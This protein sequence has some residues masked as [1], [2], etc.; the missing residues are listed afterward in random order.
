MLIGYLPEPVSF[1]KKLTFLVGESKQIS[2]NKCS[3]EARVTVCV[4]ISEILEQHET[5]LEN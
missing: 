1:S 4:R 2:D 3:E 5:K